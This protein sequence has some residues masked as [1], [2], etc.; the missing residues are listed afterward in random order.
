MPYSP[1]G[2]GIL[3]GKYHRD[4][5]F[6]DGTR[7]VD[8]AWGDWATSFLSD[9]VYDLVDVLRELAAEINCST[10]QLALAW[11]LQQPGVTSAIIGPRTS[12]HLDDN[13]S[14][15]DISLDESVV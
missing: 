1:L 5:T 3:T 13:L 9:K 15:L 14:A 2:G 8:S 6:P 12:G 7:A 11:V 4:K 10:S